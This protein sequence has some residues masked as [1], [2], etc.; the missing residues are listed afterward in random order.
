MFR[1][2]RISIAASTVAALAVAAIAHAATGQ[3]VFTGEAEAQPDATVKMKT[4]GTNDLRVKV[5]TV[6][7]FTVDCGNQDGIVKRATIKGTIKVGREG[8]FHGRD[9]N[10]DTVLN[11]RGEI[12]GR[13]AEGR[14][15]FSGVVED[16]NGDSQDCDSGRIDWTA[17]A[18]AS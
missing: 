7:D 14:F 9:D 3:L 10:G 12:D 2:L 6:R 5:F 15:R 8:K 16:Q 18:S 1:S 13:N 4:G 17:H 11:V